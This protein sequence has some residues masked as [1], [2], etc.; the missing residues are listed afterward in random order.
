MIRVIAS[1]ILFIL[2]IILFFIKN[3]IRQ[4]TLKQIIRLGGGRLSGVTWGRLIESDFWLLFSVVLLI[5]EV[6]KY[7]EH[8]VIIS[9]LGSLIIIFLQKIIILLLQKIIAGLM[10]SRLFLSHK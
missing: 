8:P 1:V 5:P 3:G 7:C 10:K 2:S 9:L 6:V 4:M